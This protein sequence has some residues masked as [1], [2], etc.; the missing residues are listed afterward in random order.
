MEVYYMASFFPI[1]G[2]ISQIEPMQSSA[3]N[4]CGCSL[5]VSIMTTY[6]GMVNLVVTP[7]TYIYNQEPLQTGDSI[8]AYYDASAPAPLIYPPQYRVT[9]IVKDMENRMTDFGYYDENLM[10]AGGT[11]QLDP[12]DST[13]VT[14]PNGQTF[15]GSPANHYLL[16]IYSTTTRSIPAVTEPSAIVVFCC[17]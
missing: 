5:L 8:T 13:V 11:L 9:A 16:V 10:N 14:Y 15:S 1:T 17:A 7:Y 3:N 2:T 4:W 12:S 6:Q